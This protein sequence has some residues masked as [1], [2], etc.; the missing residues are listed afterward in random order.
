MCIS[1]W[2]V[3]NWNIESSRIQTLNLKD[4]KIQVKWVSSKIFPKIRVLIH[5]WNFP[6]SRNEAGVE[7]KNWFSKFV[8]KAPLSANSKKKTDPTPVLPVHC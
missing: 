7:A 4:L 6:H 5:P 2:K 3:F 8:N 1:K